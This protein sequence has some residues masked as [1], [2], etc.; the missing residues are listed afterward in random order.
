[1]RTQ[2]SELIK[3]FKV[4]LCEHHFHNQQE[5]VDALKAEGFHDISQS[6][7]SRIL[8]NIGAVRTRNAKKETVYCVPDEMIVPAID[9]P[10]ASLVTDIDYNDQLVVIKTTPGG[11]Q[12]VARLLD[13]LG[14]G[15]GILGCVGGDD[16]IFVTPTR[17]T[18]ISRLY[19]TISGVL[20]Y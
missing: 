4:M 2:D 8:N 18:S 10:L 14:K 1:M 16:T 6:K 5:M 7:V 20:A 19:E 12:V 11:A 9:A 3:T 15:D 13:S 17:N